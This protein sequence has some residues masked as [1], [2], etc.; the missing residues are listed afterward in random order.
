MRIPPSRSAQHRWP[1]RT[2]KSQAGDID[3]RTGPTSSVPEPGA[4]SDPLISDLHRCGQ[5]HFE[6]APGRAT[7][8]RKSE[9]EAGPGAQGAVHGD[10]STACLGDRP[11]DRK[12]EATT[13]AIPC[14]TAGLE[15][16]EDLAQLCARNALTAVADL[17]DQGS[18]SCTHA[19]TTMSS[20]ISVNLTAFS[21]RQSKTT[22]CRSA[23]AGI[24]PTVHLRPPLAI[25][26]HGPATNHDLDEIIDID[27]GKLRWLRHPDEGEQVGGQRGCLVE[28][29]NHHVGVRLDFGVGSGI[30][31]QLRESAGDGQSCSH[32]VRTESGGDLA[33]LGLPSFF[34]L[35]R[36]EPVACCPLPIYM[37]DQQREND[38]HQDDL[39]A[40]RPT[41]GT[42]PS[43]QDQRNAGQYRD[44]AEDCPGQYSG[45]RPEAVQ[46]S[47]TCPDEVIGNGLFPD[48][49]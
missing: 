43:M 6:P 37:P 7:V 49:T 17:E 9:G 20:P 45:P 32:L 26:R 38:S 40:L 31:D 11:D 42:R 24:T 12:A 27:R 25:G 46:Q 39:A 36:H 22:S 35:N 4:P 21:S 2:R 48:Q 14:V 47:E 44:Q 1:S 18:E 3:C 23:S 41:D 8:Q 29:A 13:R 5:R 30:G 10:R 33:L 15:D 28:F 16:V 19:S 34:R